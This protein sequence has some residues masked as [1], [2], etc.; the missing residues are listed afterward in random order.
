[1]RTNRDRWRT[2]LGG[3]QAEAHGVLLRFD[4]APMTLVKTSGGDVTNRGGHGFNA[5]R[6]TVAGSKPDS[7]AASTSVTSN[8]CSSA[9]HCSHTTPWMHE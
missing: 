5:H 1:M 9:T 2:Y 4:L 7:H 3:T 8:I 6:V